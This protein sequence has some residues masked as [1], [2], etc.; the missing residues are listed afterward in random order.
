MVETVRLFLAQ[1]HW[2][3]SRDP[4]GKVY[5]ENHACQIQG[6]SCSSEKRTMERLS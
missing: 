1:A 6:F 4:G 3:N 5:E 2:I